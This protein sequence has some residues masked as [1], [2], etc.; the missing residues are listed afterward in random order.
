MEIQPPRPK[1]KRSVA[2]L[3][4]AVLIALFALIVIF[5]DVI[6]PYDHSAQSRQTISAP[7]TN[8]R[9]RDAEANLHLRPFILQGVL[10]IRLCCDTKRSKPNGFRSAC[11]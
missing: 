2:R 6:A 4:A 9:F 5:A 3:A 11:L 1:R 10:P 8:I 7:A